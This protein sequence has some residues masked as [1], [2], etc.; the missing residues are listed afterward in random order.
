MSFERRQKILELLRQKG[1]LS[2][3][4]L[5]KI[6]TEVS[7]MTLRRDLEYFETAGEAVRIRGGI[8]YIKS[9]PGAGREDLYEQ[10]LAQNQ[11][12]KNRIARIA[13]DY[14]SAGRSIFLDSGTTLMA[15]AKSLP[16]IHLSIL[17]S[18]PNIALEISKRYAPTVN[19]I[20]GLVN[21]ETLSVSGMQSMDFVEH[22]NFDLAVMAPSA[23]TVDTGFTC[24]NYSECELKKR[25]I[26]KAK[27]TVMLVDSSKIG[28]T[29]PFT[30]ARLEEIDVLVTEQEPSEELLTA[31]QSKDVTVRWE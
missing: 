11:E 29:M 6:F 25:I 30:F 13:S 22:L 2:L 18:A 15:L 9:L 24:G 4:E 19:L 27:Q 14:I 20:G 1:V 26:K 12:A 21:R 3:K 10:R 23:F 31:A 7:S 28:H 5:E 16:D 8:R 17:T